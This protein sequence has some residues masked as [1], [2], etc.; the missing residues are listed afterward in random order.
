VGWNGAAHRA[1]LSDFYSGAFPESFARGAVFQ[2]NEA[3]GDRRISGSNA[4]LLGLEKALETKDSSDAGLALSRI[5]LVHAMVLGFGGL[6]LL[7]MGDELALLND[8]GFAD[9][10]EHADDNRW[11]H[12]PR[13]PWDLVA[14]LEAEPETPASRTFA[15]LTHLARVRAT[16]APLHA[17]VPTTVV[18]SPDPAVALFVRQSAAGNFIGV[19]NVADRPA[20]VDASLL[21]QHGVVAPYDVIADSYPVRHG[22]GYELLPYQAMWLISRPR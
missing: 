11:L 12:R 1:F 17:S 13:M 5:T 9:V 4:S 21:E 15:N 14:T 22:P 10:P 3:T 16:L 20:W 18:A 2:E 19:F 7:Y 6:P 8:Y